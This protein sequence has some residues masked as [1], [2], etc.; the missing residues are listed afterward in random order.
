M[1]NQSQ[2][3]RKTKSEEWSKQLQYIW[4]SWG[5]HSHS[6]KICC[7]GQTKSC[8]QD[9]FVEKD[10]SNYVKD[11]YV[12]ELLQWSKKIIKD[13]FT[14]FVFPSCSN[15]CLNCSWRGFSVIH[16]FLMFFNKWTYSQKAWFEG[17]KE[18]RLS[19]KVIFPKL[20]LLTQ[21]ASSGAEKIFN[22]EA[23]KRLQ[24]TAISFRLLCWIFF[25]PLKT[26]SV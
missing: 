21:I 11:N 25:Q 10:N 7:A 24:L 20:S 17:Y 4:V 23:E 26:L 19:K 13:S 5:L 16:E 9:N 14:I 18:Y 8:L 12:V 22:R 1:I 6:T 3:S 15:C 2:R